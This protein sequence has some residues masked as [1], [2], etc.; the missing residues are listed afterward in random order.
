MTANFEAFQ[1]STVA[2]FGALVATVVLVIASAPHVP[3]A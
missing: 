3:L 1:R 2:A